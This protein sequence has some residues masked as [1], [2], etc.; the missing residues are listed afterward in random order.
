MFAAKLPKYPNGLDEAL[1]S[2]FPKCLLVGGL[3]TNAVKDSRQ[4]SSS[5]VSVIPIKTTANEKIRKFGTN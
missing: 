3:R 5:G 1:L 4:E 2:C